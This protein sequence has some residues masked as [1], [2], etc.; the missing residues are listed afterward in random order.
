MSYI[1]TIFGINI[2]QDFQKKTLVS[3]TYKTEIAMARL[4]LEWAIVNV[5]NICD[6]VVYQIRSD[7]LM[8]DT[9]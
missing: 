9:F 6:G 1:R 2:A 3:C 8:E 5:R 4:S 7:K